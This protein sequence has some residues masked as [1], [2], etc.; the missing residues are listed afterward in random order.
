M[1]MV[2]KLTKRSLILFLTFITLITIGFSIG[3]VKAT[4]LN[5]DCYF[6]YLDPGHGGF[7]GGATSTDKQTIEKNINLVTCIYLKKYLERT[8]IKVKLTREKDEALA[9]NKKDDIHKRV[10]LINNSSCDI[11][12]S[13]HANAYP[14]NSVKGAQTF[15]N[16]KNDQ[17]CKL[18]TNIMTKLQ[19]LD[20]TNKR[21]AKK[22][23]EKYLLDK[24]NKIGCLVELGFLTNQSE[25]E[26]LR[27]DQYLEKIAFSIYLGIIQYYEESRNYE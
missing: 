24:T 4:H 11:Y 15:Y 1:K 5:N 8:G 16:E 2:I 9:K 23:S 25:L 14:E 21:V 6:V 10:K 19:I 13:I 20:P 17:N 22:I 3:S 12:I 18:A 27:N 26:N 7:D